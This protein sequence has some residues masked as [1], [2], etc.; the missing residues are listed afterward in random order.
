MIVVENCIVLPTENLSL[1][2]RLPIFSLG[3]K[4][5]L[6]FIL[7]SYQERL[8]VRVCVCVSLSGLDVNLITGELVE[9]EESSIFQKV[10]VGMAACQIRDNRNFEMETAKSCQ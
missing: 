9:E 2:G 1:F 6:P 8:F 10:H 7:S 5:K 3:N 4:K